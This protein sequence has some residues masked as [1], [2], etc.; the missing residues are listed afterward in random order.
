MNVLE[1]KSVTRNDFFL[2]LFCYNILIVGS[3]SIF[4]VDLIPCN[5]EINC[6]DECNVF[7]IFQV[8]LYGEKRTIKSCDENDIVR[9]IKQSDIGLI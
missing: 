4:C 5:Y 6:N 3:L 7:S 2:I 8:I 9:N 1:Q